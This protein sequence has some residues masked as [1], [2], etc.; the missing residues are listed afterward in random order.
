V[1][2]PPGFQVAG[3]NS[4]PSLEVQGADYRFLIAEEAYPWE[5]P[6]FEDSLWEV[7]SSVDPS[8]EDPS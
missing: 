6:S 5:D 2:G 8:Q 1:L 4:D 3:N 7:P